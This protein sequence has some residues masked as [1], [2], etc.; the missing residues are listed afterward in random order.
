MTQICIL[1][2]PVTTA[3]GFN[4]VLTTQMIGLMV[5]GWSYWEEYYWDQIYNSIKNEEVEREK[6]KNEK[7]LGVIID[8]NLIFTDYITF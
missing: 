7:D 3:T 8:Q 6:V 2:L 4:S 5:G 1:L